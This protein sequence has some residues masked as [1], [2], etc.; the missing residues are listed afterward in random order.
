MT[1]ERNQGAKTRIG[2]VQM[3]MAEDRDENLERGIVLAGEAAKEGANLICLPE[4]FLGRY[5]CQ[6][7]DEAKF[8]MAE[9]F[10][11]PLSARMSEVAR[12]LEAAIVVPFF[13]KRAPGVYHNSAFV[14]DTDGEVLGLYRK[15]HIPDD[16]GF[17]EKYYFAPGD[18]GFKVWDTRAGKVGTL[19]CWDQWY[20]EAARLTAMQGAEAL[21]YP[22]AIGW[23]P[24][25]KAER[26]ANQVGAWQTMQR[27]HAVAN[28]C[29][30]AAANRVGLEP[31][32]DGREIEFWGHSFIVS[33]E[34]EI[35]A[36]ASDSGEEVIVAD[37]RPG[38]M[39]QI[40]IEWP[41][42]RDRRIDAYG[43]L[44]QRFLK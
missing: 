39:D 1:S 5:F 2:V 8:A 37:V 11:G 13:E 14:V 23:H 43:D 28:G 36:E 7:E 9:E 21:F 31:G 40:R 35:L 10:P 4:L 3:R 32:P 12:Q 20:P 15:M 33:P 26:G 41:F 16:P 25:E 38:L 19:I 18:L 29:Y 6:S 44:Q 27:S 34:G 30:V 24:S 17:Y 42:F 22:T